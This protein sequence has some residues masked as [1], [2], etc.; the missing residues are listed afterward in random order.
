MSGASD[1]PRQVS[2][3]SHPAVEKIETTHQAGVPHFS[4]GRTEG[5]LFPMSEAIVHCTKTRKSRPC[6]PLGRCM[7]LW[8]T[9]WATGR[10]RI[11]L[12]LHCDAHGTGSRAAAARFICRLGGRASPTQWLA[13]GD[14]LSPLRMVITWN[15]QA[16][17]Q[18]LQP[19]H[20]S[21]SCSTAC[22]FHCATS[23]LSRWES[24][25]ATHQPQPVQREMSMA[26]VQPGRGRPAGRCG[27]TRIATTADGA[28][29]T[30][31]GGYRAGRGCWQPRRIG[32]RG[33]RA[34]PSPSGSGRPQACRRAAGGSARGHCWQG[35]RHSRSWG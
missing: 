20:R 14:G 24:Q 13:S 25:A 2:C 18:S 28:G 1:G 3:R 21:A 17:A 8:I 9:E 6:F 32:S 16:T 30:P 22:F 29:A 35:G 23:K 7:T 26:G 12:G 33:R 11:L 4:A 27:V 34:S 31:A 19:V 10:S 15:G 5:V